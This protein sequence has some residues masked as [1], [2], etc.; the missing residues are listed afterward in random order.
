MVLDNYSDNFDF[1]LFC[2]IGT[3]EIVDYEI[4]IVALSWVRKK[5]PYIATV[6]LDILNYPELSVKK[7]ERS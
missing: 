7:E 6:E 4:W 3:F 5:N 1:I 2:S